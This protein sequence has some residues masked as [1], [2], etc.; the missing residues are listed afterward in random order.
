MLATTA[1]PDPVALFFNRLAQAIR[2]KDAVSLQAMLPFHLPRQIHPDI[3]R[4]IT[5]LRTVF[6]SLFVNLIAATTDFPY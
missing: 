3:Q 2:S 4:F 6:L 5:T 1:Q